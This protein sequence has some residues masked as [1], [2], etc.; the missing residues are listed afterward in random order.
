MFALRKY[1]YYLTVYNI[2]KNLLFSAIPKCLN[3][4]LI[5]KIIYRITCSNKWLFNSFE[6]KIMRSI[7]S[8]LKMVEQALLQLSSLL[9]QPSIQ[10]GSQSI[11]LN[12]SYQVLHVSFAKTLTFSMIIAIHT[13]IAGLILILY[14]RYFYTAHVL[15]SRFVRDLKG[16]YPHNLKKYTKKDCEFS[17]KDSF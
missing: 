10:Q 17:E 7:S 15:R 12:N 1:N 2:T 6:W 16:Y 4:V 5:V 3:I 11:S 13:P 8:P 14:V 9:Y